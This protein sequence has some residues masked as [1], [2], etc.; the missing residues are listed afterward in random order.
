MTILQVV[1][2]D[3]GKG[4]L[5]ATLNR[6]KKGRVDMEERRGKRKPVNFDRGVKHCQVGFEV[7]LSADLL[8]TII[9]LCP[10]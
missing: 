6:V 5:K 10:R 2:Y 7:G 3:D 4:V 9:Q 8:A 1:G